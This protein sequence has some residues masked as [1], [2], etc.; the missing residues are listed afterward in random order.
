MIW[1]L[2]NKRRS[3]KIEDGESKEAA[4]C[5]RGEK[6]IPSELEMPIEILANFLEN[7]GAD[8]RKSHFSVLPFS[9]TPY[10]KRNCSFNN[11][12]PRWIRVNL[13]P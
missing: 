11:P 10:H 2:I 6:E 5:R 4:K 12:I 3:A 7:R 1:K 9:E 8:L 13:E